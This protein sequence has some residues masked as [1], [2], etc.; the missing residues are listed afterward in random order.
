MSVL[1]TLCNLFGTFYHF[2]SL[3]YTFYHF[4]SL[5]I[6]VY[7]SL[8]KWRTVTISEEKWRKW[9]RSDKNDN[10]KKRLGR[11]WTE[12]EH[13]QPGWVTRRR[14]EGRGRGYRP[15][16]TTTMTI[17]SGGRTGLRGTACACRFQL[18]F[19]SEWRN[20]TPSCYSPEVAAANDCWIPICTALRTEPLQTSL[21]TGGLT[22][23]RW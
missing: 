6:T 18:R 5:L 22:L 20:T 7:H 11:R 17:D 15:G 16:A 23:C 14:G 12:T 8:E 2:L 21:C 1:I 4:F 9:Q 10:K 13:R 19:R 3:C